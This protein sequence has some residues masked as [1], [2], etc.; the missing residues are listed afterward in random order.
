MLYHIA[1]MIRLTIAHKSH[2]RIVT[3]ALSFHYC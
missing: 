2:I 1:S 3:L